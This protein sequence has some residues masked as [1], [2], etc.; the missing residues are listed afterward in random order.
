MTIVGLTK[1]ER[2]RPMGV[3]EKFS[4]PGVLSIVYS[5]LFLPSN[6]TMS[7]ITINKPYMFVLVG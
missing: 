6:T 1:N 2:W 5:I 3:V 7:Q 4:E